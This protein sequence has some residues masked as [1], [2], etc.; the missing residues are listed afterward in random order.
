MLVV[1]TADFVSDYSALLHKWAVIYWLAS[2]GR[3]MMY[4][5]GLFINKQHQVSYFMHIIMIMQLWI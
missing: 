3:E 4:L 5:E 2:S 1:G